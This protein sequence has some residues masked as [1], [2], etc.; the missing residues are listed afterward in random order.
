MWTE[1]T[2]ASIWL[3]WLSIPLSR[4][5]HSFT[6]DTPHHHHQTVLMNYCSSH[7]APV[8][9][10]RHTD[11]T[12][13]QNNIQMQVFMNC[14]VC[15]RCSTEEY[16][17]ILSFPTAPSNTHTHTHIPDA[18]Q[19]HQGFR[20]LA[21]LWMIAVNLCHGV[22]NRNRNVLVTGYIYTV[23]KLRKMYV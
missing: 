22:M 7:A 20:Q 19:H 1:F 15:A 8:H 14:E 18:S 12:H 10:H 4:T 17:G 2:Q 21:D 5:P 23:K 13:T 3:K 6:I 11:K 16:H 9:T